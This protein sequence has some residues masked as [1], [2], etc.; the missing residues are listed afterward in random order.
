MHMTN[1][2]SHPLIVSGMDSLVLANRSVGLPRGMWQNA[3]L[4]ARS[5]S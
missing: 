2:F 5:A 4:S 1:I 3:G